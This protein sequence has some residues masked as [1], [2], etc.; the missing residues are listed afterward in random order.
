MGCR[1][2]AAASCGG[3]VGDPGGG[4]VAGEGGAVVLRAEAVA[5]ADS[6][7]LVPVVEHGDLGDVVVRRR[8]GRRCRGGEVKARTSPERTR[9]VATWTAPEMARSVAAKEADLGAVAPTSRSRVVVDLTRRDR[10]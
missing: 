10:G 5:E 4:V 2:G 7:A 6:V 3:V 8:G 9:S 1:A